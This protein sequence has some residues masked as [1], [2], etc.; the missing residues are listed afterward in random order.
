MSAVVAVVA[1]AWASALSTSLVGVV[2]AIVVVG[3]VGIPPGR[4]AIKQEGRS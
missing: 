4:K 1:V 3:L 2:F